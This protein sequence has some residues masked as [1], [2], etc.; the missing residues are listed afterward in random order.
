MRWPDELLPPAGTRNIGRERPDAHR[1]DG[2]AGVAA[3][4]G[5]WYALGGAPD[6]PTE[7]LDGSPF[8]DYRVPGLILGGDYAPASLA[9]AWATAAPAVASVGHCCRD[10]S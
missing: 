9:A 3:L 7:W 1:P 8:A 5:A 10:G 4:A 2:T 6:V